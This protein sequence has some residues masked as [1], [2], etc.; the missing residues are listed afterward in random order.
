MHKK[1]GYSAHGPDDELPY[2]RLVYYVTCLAAS[3]L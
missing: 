1:N 3:G 2:L